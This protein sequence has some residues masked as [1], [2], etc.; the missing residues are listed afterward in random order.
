MIGINE[1][2]LAGLAL[3]A[4]IIAPGA[5]T[6]KNI[7]NNNHEKITIKT[8]I[9]STYYE[10]EC[11]LTLEYKDYNEGSLKKT[12]DYSN[13]EDSSK[14]H[15]NGNQEDA[16]QKFTFGY[17]KED[18]N[19][20]NTILD[21]EETIEQYQKVVIIRKEDKI[22]LVEYTN[23]DNQTMSGYVVNDMLVELPD[24]FIE[25]DISD[26]TIRMYIDGELAIDSLVVTGMSYESP[27]PNGCYSIDDKVSPT[28]LKGYD[29]AGNV[30][31]SRFVDYWMPFCGGIGLHDAEYHHDP[32]WGT[33]HGWR[34]PDDFGGN[35]YTYNGSHGCV[36][37]LNDVAKFI[38]ENSEVGTKVLVHK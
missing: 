5:N 25:I 30:T 18:T 24:T 26:Q 31:Y 32:E 16:N 17:I 10:S 14:K 34:T 2:A 11:E 28:F 12:I 6:A 15:V 38:Y 1:T 37:L 29:G 20:Y 33:Y 9:V 27:T 22:T 7:V 19:V 4:S 21:K 13:G 23:S 3:A 36:N 35:T 8:S